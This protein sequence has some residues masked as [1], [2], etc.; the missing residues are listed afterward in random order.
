MSN[1]CVHELIICNTSFFHHPPSLILP[2][3]VPTSHHYLYKYIRFSTIH[4]NWGWRSG[5][6]PKG[7]IIEIRIILTKKRWNIIRKKDLLMRKWKSYILH[8][9]KKWKRKKGKKTAPAEWESFQFLRVIYLLN[10][11]FSVDVDYP[12]RA[13]NPNSPYL[14]FIL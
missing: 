5:G 10:F 7:W 1:F 9:R 6:Y 4:H 11:V 12:P 14:P 3:L 2:F 8:K 13:D